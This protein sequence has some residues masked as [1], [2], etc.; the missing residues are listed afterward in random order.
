MNFLVSVPTNTLA[1]GSGSYMT[2]YLFNGPTLNYTGTTQVT[3]LVS[4]ARWQ[5][6]TI[7]GDTATLTVN[8]ATT[9]QITAPTE[10]SNVT[11]T[12]ASAIRIL[13]AS[14]T[15]TNQIGLFIESLT[16]GATDDYA[17]YMEGTPVIH[18][19]LPAASAATNI[20]LDGNNDF[21]QDTSSL[22]F[23]ENVV[24]YEFGN[25]LLMALRPRTFDWKDGV[26]SVGSHFRH[27][28]NF[29]A[30]EVWEVAPHLVNLDGDGLPFSLRQDMFTAPL[31][32]GWQNHEERIAQLEAENI[33]LR[34]RVEEVSRNGT[35]N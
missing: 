33:S 2:D 25:E 32:H 10:G 35:A 5:A 14:G 8:K 12:D 30:E 6:R 26:G 16:S 17:I 21:Q 15:P 9:I 7:V 34:T 24:D 13:N 27:D 19:S 3:T 31:V 23:K 4:T 1:S 20:S 11:L 29:I 18:G 28:H 22:R